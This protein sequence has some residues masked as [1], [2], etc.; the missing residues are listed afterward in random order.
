MRCD[1]CGRLIENAELWQLGGDPNAPTARSMR[2]LCWDC[3]KKEERAA[4]QPASIPVEARI[5]AGAPES[6]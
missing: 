1:A 2:V 6:R 5:Q 4:E 3:R